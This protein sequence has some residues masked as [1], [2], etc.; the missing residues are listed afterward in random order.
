MQLKKNT[1]LGKAK[2]KK[3]FYLIFL[4][5]IF[6]NKSFASE[7][8]FAEINTSLIDCIYDST[9]AKIDKL[10]PGTHIPIKDA[11]TFHLEKFDYTIIFAWN[12]KDEIINKEKQKGAKTIWVEY[13]PEVKLSDAN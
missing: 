6:S 12:L 4:L 5:F 13:V 3:Y 2:I 10:T 11:S 8:N 9:P 1:K 7:L